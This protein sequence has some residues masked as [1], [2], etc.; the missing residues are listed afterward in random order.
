MEKE[1]FFAEKEKKNETAKE[2][3]VNV[4]GKEKCCP[5][6]DGQTGGL[7]KK[8]FQTKNGTV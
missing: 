1:N 6:T 5:G 3:E 7:C 4:F 8:S 2:K